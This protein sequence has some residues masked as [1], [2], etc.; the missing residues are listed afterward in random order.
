MRVL[1]LLLFLS[2]SYSP[3]LSS[4]SLFSLGDFNI[5][6]LRARSRVL[7]RILF[8]ALNIEKSGAAG[9]AFVLFCGQGAFPR[10]AARPNLLTCLLR[11][12]FSGFS[13]LRLESEAD[14]N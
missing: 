2:L 12:F 13:F 5:R 10:S 7:Y 14:S 6:T 8:F 1:I 9:N 4:P 3:S 11:P